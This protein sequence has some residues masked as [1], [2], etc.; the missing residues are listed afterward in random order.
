MSSKLDFGQI[1]K[2]VYDDS[3]ESLK[4]IPSSSTSFAI[5]LDAD[6]GDSVQIQ[7]RESSSNASGIDNSYANIVLAEFD[8]TGMSANNIFSMTQINIV[9]AQVLTLQISPIASGDLWFNTSLTITPDATAGNGIAGTVL[10]NLVAKRARI[11][12]AAA[13]TSG[14]YDIYALARG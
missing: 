10:S 6:D 13:I 3:T 2:N 8:I 12:T 14:S 9:G 5:E 1:I 7:G 4:T 11:V